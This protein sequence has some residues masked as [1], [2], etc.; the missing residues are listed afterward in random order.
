VW[1]HGL[2]PDYH[3][4]RGSYGGYTFALHDRRPG[5]GAYN[6]RPELVASLSAAYGEAITAEDVFDAILCLLS[7]T[8]FTLRFAEDL[9]DV[10][11]HV[12]FPYSGT[13]SKMQ[14]ASAA[15]S[16]R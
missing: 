9:E 12:P 14:C 13:P 16:G 11:P 15:R 2:L 4:F 8:S 1:C 5:H 6:L 3:S 7:A 10:F